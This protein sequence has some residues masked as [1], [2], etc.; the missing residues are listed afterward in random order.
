MTKNETLAELYALRFSLTSLASR[1]GVP[2][3]IITAAMKE[4][5]EIK[6][7][8]PEEIYYPKDP[9]IAKL[10][11]EKSL[12]ENKIYWLKDDLFKINQE[13][14]RVQALPEKVNTVF[15]F[16]LSTLNLPFLTVYLIIKNIGVS[17]WVLASLVAAPFDKSKRLTRALKCYSRPPF[18]YYRLYRIVKKEAEDSK[19]K[20][21]SLDNLNQQKLQ[22]EQ[23]LKN[24][25][26][27]RK[28]H[29]IKIPKDEAMMKNQAERKAKKEQALRVYIQ[30]LNEAQA[31]TEETLKIEKQI[32][33]RFSKVLSIQN[34]PLLDL[35]IDIINSDRA[36]NVKEA[37]HFI[38]E[39]RRNNNLINAMHSAEK[40]IV[41]EIKNLSAEVRNNSLLIANNSLLIAKNINN[42]I[43]NSNNYQ[44][45]SSQELVKD[46]QEVV[47]YSKYLL[48][49]EMIELRNNGGYKK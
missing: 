37:M 49:R 32:K 19:N 9:E 42:N 23:E 28:N 3:Q 24:I 34:W 26:N 25:Y 47:N 18:G 8:A 46:T 2:Q 7:S 31:Y 22:K 4:A 43:S 15:Y 14:E 36:D 41:K 39:E 21:L 20:S 11:R 1:K 13:I 33:T 6:K 40:N 16:I 27:E 29:P 17:L 12:Q 5:E 48:E 10:R 30:G 45:V 44:F 35:I 38:D